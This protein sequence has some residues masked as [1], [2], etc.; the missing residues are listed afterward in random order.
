[1][2]KALWV[3]TALLALGC[4]AQV[5]VNPLPGASS[6]P[7]ATPTPTTMPSATPSVTP[8]ATPT[9]AQS[10]AVIKDSGS[11][12]TFGYT[13][14]LQSGGSATYSTGNGLGSGKV[15][16]ALAQKLFNDLAAAGALSGL[17][18]GQC[19]KSASFGTTTTIS[20]DGQ[21][22]P[23]LQCAGD[24]K[25]LALYDDVKGVASALNVQNVPRSSG[26]TPPDLPGT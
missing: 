2:T 15:D 3:T 24:A 11:T 23:D 4:S 12:N 7:G 25:G 17:A 18:A 6:S 10:S 19:A 14:L 26:S 22:S 21:T 8:S 16:E 13:I 1:M 9:A 5:S 20:F